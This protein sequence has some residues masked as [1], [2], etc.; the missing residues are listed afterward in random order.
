MLRCALLLRS[1]YCPLISAPVRPASTTTPCQLSEGAMAVRP[2][3]EW[4]CGGTG[5]WTGRLGCGLPLSVSPSLYLSPSLASSHWHGRD[6]PHANKDPLWHSNSVK[7]LVSP[8]LLP[9][10]LQKKKNTARVDIIW[11]GGQPPRLDPPA[12][13]LQ[14][15]ISSGLL[16]SPKWAR[17][18]CPTPSPK[19]PS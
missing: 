10:S 4:G 9:L 7:P 3:P 15:E 2:D 16:E 5:L 6:R 8:P 18:H 17:R 12:L 14:T 13:S 1:E 11:T 19:R